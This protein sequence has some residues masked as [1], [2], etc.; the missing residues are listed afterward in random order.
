[1]HVTEASEALARSVRYTLETMCFA[2]A[3]PAPHAVT[4]TSKR[5]TVPFRGSFAGRL[6]FE[7]GREAA[8]ALTSAALGLHPGETPAETYVKDA[9]CELGTVICGCWLSTLDSSACLQLGNPELT[10]TAA[11]NSTETPALRLDFQL[12]CGHL[13]VCV[14]LD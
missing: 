14:Q 1:M 4:E 2:E 7:V 5:A 12:D 8:E 9:L 11:R 10:E 6:N 3:I 13:A